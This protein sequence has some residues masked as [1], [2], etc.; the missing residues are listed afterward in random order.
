LDR[1]SDW[2]LAR[3]AEGWTVV[4][5]H[6]PMNRHLAERRQ[7]EPTYQLAG[8]GVHPNETGHWLMALPLILQFG[9]PREYASLQSAP[10]LLRLYPNGPA[11]LKLVQQRQRMLKDAWLTDTGHQ[12][13]GMNR[14]LPLAEAQAQALGLQAQIRALAAPRPAPQTHRATR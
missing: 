3:R 9:A 1:Y 14:G 7:Q 5:L 4:D 10:A 11:V 6:G 2:L 13:P 12:R 8:D